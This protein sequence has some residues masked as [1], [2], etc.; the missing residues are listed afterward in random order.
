MP[1]PYS[2]EDFTPNPDL[3][4]YQQLGNLV[5]E[6]HYKSFPRLST[7]YEAGSEAKE[8]DSEY[9]EE[10]EEDDDEQEDE[11][12]EQVLLPPPP[13]HFSP[14]EALAAVSDEMDLVSRL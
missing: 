3:E 13:S 5:A 6:L 9:E 11:L 14:L 4:Q 10:D 1:G 12:Y 8:D 2:Y 7:D